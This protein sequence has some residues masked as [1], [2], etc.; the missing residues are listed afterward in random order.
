MEEQPLEHTVLTTKCTILQEACRCADV[1]ALSSMIDVVKVSLRWCYALLAGAFL[2]NYAVTRTAG[3]HTI[4]LKYDHSAAWLSRITSECRTW[5]SS[6]CERGDGI[7]DLRALFSASEA[8]YKLLE[9]VVK[10]IQTEKRQS[11]S[12]ETH[13]MQK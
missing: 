7:I 6:M 3:E 5:R 4:Q 2:L 12:S 10:V 1:A 13:V 9:V 8:D 11:L